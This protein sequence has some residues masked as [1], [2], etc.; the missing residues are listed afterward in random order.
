[1]F[2]FFFPIEINADTIDFLIKLEKDNKLAASSKALYTFVYQGSKLLWLIKRPESSA[3]T[4]NIAKLASF[5]LLKSPIWD[6]LESDDYKL[7]RFPFDRL[8]D[9]SLCLCKL[10]GKEQLAR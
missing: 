9:D 5:P 2:L 4:A 7:T 1:M 6:K 3:F 8:D 10:W